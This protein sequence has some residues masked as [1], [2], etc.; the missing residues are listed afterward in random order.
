MDFC[1]FSFFVFGRLCRFVF[2]ESSRFV[3]SNNNSRTVVVV[4]TYTY[5]VHA[6]DCVAQRALCAQ[7]QNAGE[8]NTDLFRKL[9]GYSVSGLTL[10]AR[11]TATKI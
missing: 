4:N 9:F 2:V 3:A 5:F 6:S 10:G 1:C 8:Q 7:Q 11:K